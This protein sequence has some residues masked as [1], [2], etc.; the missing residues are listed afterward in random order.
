MSSHR[1][2]RGRS[3]RLP[4]DT[5]LKAAQA[6]IGQGSKVIDTSCGLIEVQKGGRRRSPAGRSRQRWRLRY[7]AIP[8]LKQR[9]ELSWKEALQLWGQKRKAGCAP[10]SPQ[11]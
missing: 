11:W 8:L 5:D 4:V 10:C 6:R 1:S 2:I 9:M 3:D 7:Q